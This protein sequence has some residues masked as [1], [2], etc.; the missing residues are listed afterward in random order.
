MRVF[1][2]VLFGLGCGVAVAGASG[3]SLLWP[4][5]VAIVVGLGLLMVG[6]SDGPETID[7]TGPTPEQRLS[8]KDLGPAVEQILT[9]SEEQAS[10]IV[11]S[12]Q[13]ESERILAAARAEAAEIRAKAGERPTPTGDA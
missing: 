13:H 9:L 6:S 1:G 10:A 5:V 4:A 2:G 12:A 11:A 7:G 8:F 3:I